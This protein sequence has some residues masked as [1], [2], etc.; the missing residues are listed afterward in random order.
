[1]TS[2]GRGR[3]YADMT[4]RRGF[5]VLTATYYYPDIKNAAGEL[6]PADGVLSPD[7]IAE[8]TFVEVDDAY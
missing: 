7:L 8:G 6:A 3:Q 4:F 1:M 5:V 2:A